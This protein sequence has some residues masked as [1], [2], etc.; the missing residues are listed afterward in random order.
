M[1]D[2]LFGRTGW[3]MTFGERAAL[4][5]I[6]T[7]LKPA[8]AVEIGT[9]NGGSLRRIAAHSR[10]VHAFDLDPRPQLSA[11]CPNV[12]FHIGDSRELVPR[13][14][15]DL[16]ATGRSV[17]FALV[18]GDASALGVQA[19]VQAL[20][21]SAAVSQTVILVHD[22]LN[23]AKRAALQSLQGATYVDLDFVPGHVYDDELREQW[24]GFALILVGA[25]ALADD[26][27]MGIP[28]WDHAE[29]VR[30]ARAG[31][32]PQEWGGD[33]IFRLETANREL[34]TGLQAMQSSVSW[35]ITAPLRALKSLAR[36][37]AP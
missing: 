5:G 6:L 35:R 18:D 31:D 36:R 21:D 16:A 23:E 27:P 29:L 14:L 3:Q 1:V 12:T 11:E 8:V 32:D 26:V 19:D 30:R 25:L 34:T 9:A 22:S 2:D 20:L 4:E 28:R 24:C 10:E 17:D 13:V 15:A 7:S 33:M 37:P